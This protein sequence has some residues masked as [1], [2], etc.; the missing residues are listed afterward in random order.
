MARS[1]S[2]GYGFG[3]RKGV[4]L[5]RGR[6][7]RLWYVRMKTEVLIADGGWVSQVKDLTRSLGQR[8]KIA[9]TA[10]QL[11]LLGRRQPGSRLPISGLLSKA[12]GSARS[13]GSPVT[14]LALLHLAAL[15]DLS[16]RGQLR[17][18]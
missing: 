12:C 14:A 13:L 7:G 18:G 9:R 17:V 16:A 1:L 11:G 10:W 8:V 5:D 2:C 4:G 15:V 3:V 6:I